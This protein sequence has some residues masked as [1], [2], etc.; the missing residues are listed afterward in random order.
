M[1]TRF[2]A[3]PPP[4]DERVRIVVDRV[5]NSLTINDLV[6]IV[7]SMMERGVGKVGELNVQAI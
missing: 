7:E 4:L 5:D 2:T 3:P 1:W 6:D